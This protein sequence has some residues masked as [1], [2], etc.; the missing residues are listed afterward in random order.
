MLRIALIGAGLLG[1]THL[2]NWKLISDTE[3]IGFYEPD[4]DLAF[5]ITEQYQ[6][7]RFLHAGML[8]DACDVVDITVPVISRFEWCEKAIKKGKHVFI[9]SPMSPNIYEARQVVNLAEESGIKLQ[10]QC[11]ERFDPSIMAI[12]D[13]QVNPLFIEMDHH[14]GNDEENKNRSIVYSHLIHDMGVILSLVKSDIKTITASGVAVVADTADM[15]NVR[16]EFH[17]GCV[18]NLTCNRLPGKKE[19]TLKLFQKDS[20]IHVNMLNQKTE[21]LKIKESTD[22]NVFAF[23]IETDAGTKTL[24]SEDLLV[25]GTNAIITEL[26]EFKHAILNNTKPF[27]SEIDG[28]MAIDVAHHVYSKISNYAMAK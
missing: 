13:M 20:Y 14:T 26:E 12:K 2:K 11:T 7:P 23:D 16:L 21:M 5:E 17:N 25:P 22:H 19:K 4:D 10:V 8:L 18:A 6:L 28:L 27:I 15:V 9:P 3:I 1:K 24:I